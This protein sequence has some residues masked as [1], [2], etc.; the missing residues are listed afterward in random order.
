MTSRL[1]RRALLHWI[2]ITGLSLPVLWHGP[3]ADVPSPGAR[4]LEDF[5]AALLRVLFPHREVAPATYRAAAVVLTGAIEADPGL[6]A[7]V[8]AGRKQLDGTGAQPWLA[9]E[10]AAQS[11]ALGELQQQPFFAALRSL[12]GLVFYNTPAVWAVVGYEGSSFEKGG[13]LNRG[14]DDIDWLPD[15]AN[16]D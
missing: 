1:H 4:E 7:V 8:A 9:R 14:F 11:A 3:L 13:Y 6:A 2:A 12:G 10:Q 16:A 5:A 15:E